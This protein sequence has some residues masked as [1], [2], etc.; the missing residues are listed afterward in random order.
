MQSPPVDSAVSQSGGHGERPDDDE[1]GE[2]SAESEDPHGGDPEQD[3]AGAHQPDGERSRSVAAPALPGGN[4]HDHADGG[5]GG[6]PPV[7]SDGQHLDHAFG[8]GD[9]LQLRLQVPPPAQRVREGRR[10][11][12]A[13]ADE[14]E[15]RP[16][17]AH[18]PS[19]LY[20]PGPISS[21]ETKTIPASMACDAIW[22]PSPRFRWC[23]V[24]T[25][26]VK[27]ISRQAGRKAN[28]RIRQTPPPASAR[29]ARNPHTAGIWVIPRLAMAPPIP[30]HISTPPMSLG[31]P[32]MTN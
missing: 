1:A 8:G 20:L 31:V 30:F 16:A 12:P 6:A 7:P 22:I 2:V 9:L 14:Q 21:S 24:A 32:W 29:P 25:P 28:P 4:Q 10:H 18:F 23:M 26:M 17:A 3:P 5:H 27:A 13:A 15:D 11:H 19:T